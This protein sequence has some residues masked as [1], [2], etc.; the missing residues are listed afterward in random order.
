MEHPIRLVA[1]ALACAMLLAPQAYGAPAEF[2]R[3]RNVFVVIGYTPGG[4]YDLY[5]RLLARHLGKHI[6][7]NPTVVPQNMPGAGSLKAANYLYTIAPKDGSVIGTFA[8]GMG[9]APLLGQAKFDARRFAW[10]GSIAKDVMLC[11]SWNSSP[12]RKWD[13]V[14]ARP[15]LFGGVAAGN[16]PDIYAKLYN[17]VLGAKIRLATGFPGT[18]DIALAMQRREVDG[19]CGIAWSTVKAEHGD[20]LRDA[21]VRVLLQAAAAKAPD[22]PNVPLAGTFVRTPRGRQVLN[23]VLASQ[24]MARPFA[25]PPGIPADREAILRRAFDETMKDPAFLSDARG[26]MLD[27][28]P[29]SGA[30][31]DRL[32]AELY[33]TPK[34]VVTE[35]TNVLVN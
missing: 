15:F 24:I 19:L 23:F 22:L 28:D 14:M 30:E 25:A 29:A 31:I 26:L 32:I 10:L 6:P 35:A 18:N 9:S 5:A 13:D 7:G 3:G 33:A 1:Y 12:I 8:H 20:W 16:A 27:V 4:G 17:A 11:L 2:Y 21:K 34:D